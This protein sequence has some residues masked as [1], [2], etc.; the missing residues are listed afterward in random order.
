MAGPGYKTEA[1]T[2]AQAV[3]AFEQCAA[4]AQNAMKSLQSTLE[5]TLA[6]YAGDQQ[7]AFFGLLGQI[8]S[9]MTTASSE[10]NTMSTLV[11]KSQANY[12][13]GD[14]DAASSLQTVASNG[15]GISS[16]LSQL[17]HV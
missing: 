6:T 3:K 14:T 12:T 16:V 8:Q 13:Q 5:E 17:G 2:M 11:N 10:I 4:D 15:S 9:D 1:A 7:R